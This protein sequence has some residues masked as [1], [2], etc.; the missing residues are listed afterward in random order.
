MTG[1][2][3]PAPGTPLQPR[4]QAMRGHALMRLPAPYAMPESSA[5]EPYTGGMSLAVGD[6]GPISRGGII[7]KPLTVLVGPNGCGKTHV[8]RLLHSVLRA[9]ERRT[10]WDLKD[11]HVLKPEKPNRRR[12]PPSSILTAEP[13]RIRRSAQGGSINS[14]ICGHVAKVWSKS[15]KAG[16]ARIMPNPLRG[17]IRDGSGHFELD[18]ES[19]INRGRFACKSGPDGK[20]QTEELGTARLEAIFGKRRGDGGASP[21]D[22]PHQNER[23]MRATVP[24]TRDE[25]AVLEALKEGVSGRAKS[26]L[27]RSVYFSAGW[28]GAALLM[29]G[30]RP[31]RMSGGNGPHTGGA[32]GGAA[33][34]PDWLRDMDRRGGAFARMA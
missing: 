10:D 4:S 20:L 25:R 28:S 33:R 32:G 11:A 19:G 15:F 1:K 21:D 22:G 8:E 31:K 6:F 9:E 27:N 29:D 12:P 3:L 7:L 5:A 24:H 18:I 30:V 14:D 17:S 16:L 13:R 34:A 2:G 26:R 23:T